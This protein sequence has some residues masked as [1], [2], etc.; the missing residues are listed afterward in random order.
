MKNDK[1]N[2][3]RNFDENQEVGKVYNWILLFTYLK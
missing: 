3:L 1:E 2:I